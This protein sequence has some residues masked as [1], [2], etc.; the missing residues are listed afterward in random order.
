MP[1]HGGLRLS[2]FVMTCAVGLATASSASANDVRLWGCQGPD[3]TALG[4]VGCPT[5]N[6]MAPSFSTVRVNS[7]L[8]LREVSAL[9]GEGA[10]IASTY[11]GTA[12]DS[13]VSNGI[14]TVSAPVQASNNLDGGDLRFSLSGGTSVQRLALRVEDRTP[15]TAST[16]GYGNNPSGTQRVTAWGSDV[17][18]GLDKAEIYIDGVLAASAPFGYPDDAPATA[19]KPEVPSTPTTKCHDLA[20]GDAIA[21]LP[22]DND[23]LAYG[24]S[25]M[26]LDTN[27][28]LDGPHVMTIRIYDAA[29][30]ANDVLRDYAMNITNHPN[31]GSSSADLKIGSGNSPTPN[32]AANGGG[33]GGVAGETAT[34]CNSPRLSMELSQKP[35]KISHGRPVLKYAKR[36]RFRGRLTCI[37]KGKRKSAPLKTPVELLNVIGKKTY[38]KGGATVRKN[39]AITIIL[40][41]KTSRT[42]VF[43][44]T[45]PDGRRSQ[46]KLKIQVTK[47]SR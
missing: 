25:T 45:N 19:D 5:G 39:G 28:W 1:R 32:G 36:Y 8:E 20:G 26:N 6:L 16:G 22:I 44:Y 4:A 13:P 23:C 47:K 18:V 33:S 46:V 37:V 34:S 3:G 43:R 40:A 11:N 10:R 38:R 29:G 31:L 2:V 35:L 7:G 12:V 42:L 24:H 15:P 17:G 9:I 14:A 41:Y 27:R 30:N 21:D